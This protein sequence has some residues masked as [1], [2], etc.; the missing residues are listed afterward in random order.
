MNDDRKEEKRERTTSIDSKSIG[1]G[2]V[3]GRRSLRTLSGDDWLHL[4]GAA[5][6]LILGLAAVAAAIA[7]LV[8]PVWLG[9]LFSILGSANAIMAVVRIYHLF[10][11][12][13][14]CGSLISQAI[15]RT[16]RFQN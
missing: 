2:N 4:A 13:R 12:D 14:L 5:L 1:A 16:V 6:Q 15:R 7:G 10:T 3:S 9:T 8:W 11:S